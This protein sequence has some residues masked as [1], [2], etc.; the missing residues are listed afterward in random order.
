[1]KNPWI[2]KKKPK[3][4]TKQSI[5]TWTISEAIHTW[6][7]KGD[8]QYVNVLDRICAIND[9]VKEAIQRSDALIEKHKGKGLDF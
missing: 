6:L 1:M 9:V 2:N 3:K 4:L 8:D 5:M 7:Q